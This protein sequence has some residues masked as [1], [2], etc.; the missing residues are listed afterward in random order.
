MA[1]PAPLRV[2]FAEDDS[3]FRLVE[4]ALLR[5]RT[6]QVERVL[7]YFLGPEAEVGAQRLLAAADRFGLG[8]DIAT[9]VRAE[10][11]PLGRHLGDVDVLVVESE[12]VDA[13]HLAQAGERLKLIV[14]FGR[15]LDNIDTAAATQRGIAVATHPRRTNISCA[16]HAIGLMLALSRGIVVA[17]DAVTRRLDDPSRP[18]ASTGRISTR[19][20]W[21]GLT[22]IRL[23]HNQV[24][25]L[26]GF[27]E[28]ARE[29]AARA[30]ALGMRVIYHKRK[31]VD[32]ASLPPELRAARAVSMQELLAQSDVLS[33]HVPSNATT[34]RLVDAAALATM[35]PTAVLVNTSRGAIVDERALEAALRSG[36]IAGAALDVHREEPVPVD[37]GLLRLDNVVWTPH[38]AAGTGWSVIDEVDS[39]VEALARGAR[40]VTGGG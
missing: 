38:V 19:F 23:L 37:C 7:D 16:E 8:S 31:P 2:A 20:N 22:G 17:H 26:L 1:S 34:E 12:P 9:V 18:R 36:A 33:I 24:L 35:K 29:V 11:E 28:I 14:K 32:P 3:M 39:V 5:A 10:D 6:A 13:R 25:G 27:G 15:I 30:I 40:G 21:S 4:S